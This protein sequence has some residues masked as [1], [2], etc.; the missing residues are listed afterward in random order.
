M[1][2]PL[3]THCERCALPQWL[4][5]RQALTIRRL[6]CPRCGHRAS[7]Q[8]LARNAEKVLS[9]PEELVFLAR[10]GFPGARAQKSRS[11]RRELA[12]LVQKPAA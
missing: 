8:R 7:A 2:L 11:T 10:I 5:P 12:S 1:S 9:R 3:R 4:A 6:E